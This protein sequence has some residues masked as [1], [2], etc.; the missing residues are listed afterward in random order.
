M[1]SGVRGAPTCRRNPR[2]NP[3]PPSVV[4]LLKATS[5]MVMVAKGNYTLAKGPL[6]KVK[7]KRTKGS[8]FPC[9]RLPHESRNKEVRRTNPLPEVPCQKFRSQGDQG[10]DGLLASRVSD[11]NPLDHGSTA[12]LHNSFAFSLR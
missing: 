10:E 9:L 4:P 3:F 8:L 6:L 1:S 2:L 12:R 5:D 7:T 11:F